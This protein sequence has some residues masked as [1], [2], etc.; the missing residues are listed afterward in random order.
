MPSETACG[1]RRSRGSLSAAA[2]PSQPEVEGGAGAGGAVRTEGGGTFWKTARLAGT[3]LSSPCFP[4]QSL[5]LLFGLP[6]WPSGG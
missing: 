1:S 2:P 6:A 3:A 4:D 5:P